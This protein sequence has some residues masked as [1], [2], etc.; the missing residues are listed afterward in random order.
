[1]A[2]L[3]LQDLELKDKRVL[4]RVDFNVPLDENG[5]ITDETRITASLPT[6]RYILS[7]GGK[8]ILMSHL[9]RPK[10][11]RNERLSLKPC[12]EA[13]SF[14]LA[15]PVHLAPDCIGPLVEKM[16]QEMGQDEVLL[17]ENLRFHR[18]EEHPDEE[19]GFAGQLAKLGDV[20]VDDAFGTAHRAHASTVAC[21]KL[22]PTT[23]AAGCLLAA[24]L[25]FLGEALLHPKRPFVALI[26]GAKVSTKLG[27][28]KALSRKVD[29]LLI[30][31]GM[32]YTFLKARG[33][34]VGGSLVEDD[35]L[36]Q[37]RLIMEECL[38][39][40]VTL[41]L[42]EDLVI[43]AEFKNETLAEIV[44]TREGIPKGWQ[45]LDIGPATVRGWIPLLK[46]AATIFWNGPVGV[47]EFPQFA[48]GT[49]EIA[50]ILTEC[51]GITIVGGG[52]SLA[53]VNA[54]GLADQID[55]LSTGGGAALEFIEYGHLPGVDALTDIERC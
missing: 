30:G 2:K 38:K 29:T 51:D 12:A 42:P 3:G 18:G 28:L 48:R 19:P 20:Y 14:Y 52:D 13:L 33:I 11:V 22:F 9:G 39:S 45:G 40:G 7:Q 25:R 47:F 6:L 8:P 34:E 5:H 54:S 24:E 35:A 43:A 46:A 44:P 16:A 4:V 55:H 27:V 37:A 23:A 17:L 31:G 15:I 53:A 26:G 1:M 36:D 41:L 32:A 49:F 21:A 50:K 10:G